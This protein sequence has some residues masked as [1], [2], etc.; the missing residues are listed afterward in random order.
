M[1]RYYILDAPGTFGGNVAYIRSVHRTLRLARKA[2]GKSNR[3]C[4]IECH[5]DAAPKK[6]R[7]IYGDMYPHKR[8]VD[9]W[10]YGDRP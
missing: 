4:I 5:D 6:G 7:K 2:K 10:P 1:T 9:T 3:Y 8:I